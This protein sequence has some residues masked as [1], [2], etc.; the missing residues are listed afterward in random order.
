MLG[1][2]VTA[3]L[4]HAGQWAI[5]QYL[6]RAAVGSPYG[7]AARSSALLVW[8]YYSAVIVFVGAE[9]TQQMGRARGGGGTRAGAAHAQAWQPRRSRGR[10]APRRLPLSALTSRRGPPPAHC[11][12]TRPPREPEDILVTQN[13]R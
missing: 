9:F 12:P 1:G 5:S 4:F 3:V 11:S 2:A 7:A 13:C 6:A 10:P 8:V